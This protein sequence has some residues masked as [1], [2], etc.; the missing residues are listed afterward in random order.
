MAD[1][2]F[3]TIVMFSGKNVP[4]GWLI[5]DGKN[6]TPNLMDRFV[7][8]GTINNIGASNNKTVENHDDKNSLKIIQISDTASLNLDVSI[9]NHALT[10][11]EIPSHRH[12]QGDL[13]DYDYGFAFEHW[14]TPYSGHWINGGSVNNNT[15]PR[16]A[17][18]TNSIG[19]G[20]GHS[21][22]ASIDS[23]S[24]RH[25]HNTDIMPAYYILAYIIYVG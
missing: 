25:Q 14:S 8:G 3:G 22:A 17:P 20:K 2:P 10:L 9:A 21:H 24:T 1:I 6:D 12:S 15:S 5:C 18:Y 11:D 4:A 7:L 16:Y 23:T 19:G 13:Y